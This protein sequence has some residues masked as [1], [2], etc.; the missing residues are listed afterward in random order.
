MICEAAMVLAGTQIDLT[1]DGDGAAAAVP[2]KEAAAQKEAAAAPAQ[3]A[4]V[5]PPTV[6]EPVADSDVDLPT[7]VASQWRK[8]SSHVQ[9]LM[10]TFT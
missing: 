2:A 10:P 5:Q 1:L 4:A 3:E 7:G 9:V 8:K 6:P